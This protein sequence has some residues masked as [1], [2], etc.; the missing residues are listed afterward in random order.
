MGGSHIHAH[1]SGAVDNEVE[2]ED[3]AFNAI[4]DFLAFLP[5]S[6]YELP[7]VVPNNDPVGREEEGLLSIIPRDRREMYQVR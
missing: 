5:C 4:G 6:V 2:S 7:P 3:D 1:I